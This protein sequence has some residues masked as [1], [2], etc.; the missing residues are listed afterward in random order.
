VRGRQEGLKHFAHPELGRYDLEF[1]VFQ[2][3]EQSSLRLHLYA[4]ADDRSERVLREA[5]AAAAAPEHVDRHE[6]PRWLPT[7]R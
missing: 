7:T 3:A 4:P 2:L 1:T 6:P 5:V